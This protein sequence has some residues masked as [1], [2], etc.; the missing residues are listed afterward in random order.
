MLN[1]CHSIES[2]EKTETSLIV[3]SHTLPWCDCTLF[4]LSFVVGH[5]SPWERLFCVREG[6]KLRCKLESNT[7]KNECTYSSENPSVICFSAY[8]PICWQK[9]SWGVKKREREEERKNVYLF[10]DIEHLYSHK[11]LTTKSLLFKWRPLETILWERAI[12]EET[13]GLSFK[14]YYPLNKSIEVCVCVCV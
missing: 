9:E 3:I 7:A 10:K 4:S 14:V 13:E 2:S 8:D 6:K 5:F 11:V 12:E 1:T